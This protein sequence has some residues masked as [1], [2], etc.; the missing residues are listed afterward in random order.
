[1]MDPIRRL[2]TIFTRRKLGII[3]AM[4]I[5]LLMMV[6]VTYFALNRVE[7]KKKSDLDFWN[8]P[9]NSQSSEYNIGRNEQPQWKPEFLGQVNMHIF[10]DW[11]GGAVDQLRKNEM[12]PLYPH[13]R[14]TIRGLAVYPGWENYGLRIFGYIHPAINGEYVFAIASDDNS[15]FWLSSD[16]STKNLELL[17]FL[18]KT[19]NEWAAP[20]EYEKFASQISDPVK[21]SKKKRYYFEIIY[22]QS[23]AMD[24][25]E[26][27]WRL[28]KEDSNFEVITSEYLSLYSDESSLLDVDNQIIPQTVASKK[29]TPDP[30]YKPD[31]DMLK[32]DKRDTVYKLPLLHNSFVDNEFPKCSY[33]PI[34]IY[35]NDTITRYEGINHV[36]YSSVYP[37]DYT[38][39]ATEDIEEQKCFYVKDDTVEQGEG[40]GLMLKFEKK[41][42]VEDEEIDN[43]IKPNWTQIFNVKPVD[44]HSKQSDW[45]VHTCKRAGNIIMPQKEVM[46]II[47]AFRY[48]LMST[49]NTRELII[50]QVINVEKKTKAGVGSRFLLEVEM[51]DKHGRNFLMSNYFYTTKNKKNPELPALCSPE[52]FSWDPEAKV[53]VI[54]TVKNQGKWVIHFL[55]E[56]QRIY[57]ETGDKNFNI[58]IVDYNSTDIDVEKELQ[59]AKLPSYQFRLLNGRFAKSLGI[60]SGIDLVQDDNS[61]LF[62]CDLH[63]HFPSSIIE[64]VRK[65]TVQGKMVFAPVLMRLGCGSTLHSPT[66]FWETEGYGLVGIYKSDMDRIGG[67]NIEE[68]SDKWGGEDWELLDRIILH[69]LEVE[70][71]HMRN[72]A[73]FYHSKRGMWNKE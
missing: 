48:Q 65:H 37:N 24:H 38:R 59:N 62:M 9:E 32:E 11:C 21:L 41:V 72:F 45:V 18:G 71:L 15:E 26:L 58:I 60:Q 34:Y 2:R 66:G 14:T 69:K 20:G 70:R 16:E 46:P 49:S 68:F 63:I 5:C 33:Y 1:M 51:E 7:R 19:G 73:H 12:F 43:M 28:N 42:E 6:I 57:E 23:E 39:L 36:R 56:M 3:R 25:V 54:L 64:N 61:I 29:L 13:S 40:F 30:I 50:K 55:Q 17:A 8:L 44:F 53:H 4:F 67:M 27:A 52:H 31:M 35:D 10:E 47:K 22:K